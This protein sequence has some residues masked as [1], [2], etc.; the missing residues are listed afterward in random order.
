MKWALNLEE[1]TNMLFGQ[2]LDTVILL[3]AV[4]A[5]AIWATKSGWDDIWRP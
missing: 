4:I 5:V 3:I 1:G 2:P